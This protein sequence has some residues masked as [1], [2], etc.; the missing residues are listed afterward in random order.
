MNLSIVIPVYNEEESVD[1][2]CEK[3]HEALSPLS[4]KY[5]VVLV[6]DGSKDKTWPKLLENKQKYAY[7]HLI[8]FRRNFGQTAAMAAGLD[9]AEGEVIITMDADLQNDPKDIPKLLDAMTDEIDVVSGWRKDRKDTFINRR[10]PSILANGLISK[11]TGVHLHDYGCTLKAYR[12]DVIKDVRLYGEMHRF[13]PALA[14]WVGGSVIEIPVTHHARQFGTSK[15]G[16][17]RTFR[18]VLDLITVKFLLRYSTGPMQILGKIGL[19]IGFLGGALIGLIFVLNLIATFTGLDFW[20]ADLVKRPVW[21]IMGF[22]FMAFGIQFI[23]LGLLS[24]MTIRTYHES[25]DKRIYAVREQV[26]SGE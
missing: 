12:K 5:E 2:L 6:D 21:P 7:L 26:P 4:L 9:A 13:I 20:G 25:Q 17:G 8:R 3:L 15:Y 14:H 19:Q 16:I 1:L 11:I 10:L 18:V 23:G 24:E 22:M